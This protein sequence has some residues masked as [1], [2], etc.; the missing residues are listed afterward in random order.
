MNPDSPLY[1]PCPA[2]RVQ[3]LCHCSGISPSL[4]DAAVKCGRDRGDGL[5]VDPAVLPEWCL[6]SIP[7]RHACGR[8]QERPLSLGNLQD[9]C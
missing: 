4:G 9:L 2:V 6:Q 7:Y 8:I 3:A 1:V 5:A